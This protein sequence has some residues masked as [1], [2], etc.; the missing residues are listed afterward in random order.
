MLMRIIFIFLIIVFSSSNSFSQIEISF[1]SG[2]NQAQ[3]K[4]IKSTRSHPLVWNPQFFGGI[5][6]K[7]ESNSKLDISLHIQY[8]LKGNKFI[9]DEEDFSKIRTINFDLIPELEYELFPN[10]HVLSGLNFGLNIR[11]ERRFPK[12]PYEEMD[13]EYIQDFD[14]GFLVG[15]KYYINPKI[16][17]RFVHNEGLIDISDRATVNRRNQVEQIGIGIVLN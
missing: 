7:F 16:Y 1:L 4:W 9:I 2:I 8:S 6:S 13:P 12:E 11:D 17:L 3:L 10:F 5:T 15:V 14:F